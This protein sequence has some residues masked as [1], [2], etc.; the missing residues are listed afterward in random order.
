MIDL[1]HVDN[2]IAA[3]A[4]LIGVYYHARILL[5]HSHRIAPARAWIKVI[6]IVALLMA[7]VLQFLFFLHIVLD[8]GFYEV[9]A[10]MLIASLLAL[11]MAD[12]GVIKNAG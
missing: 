1:V 2:L 7:A 5:S 9:N 4:A 8:G 6:C 11:A 3:G 12:Y 10:E